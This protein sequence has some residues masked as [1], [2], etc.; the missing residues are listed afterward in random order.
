[1][2]FL[3]FLYMAKSYNKISIVISDRDE[4]E[5]KIKNSMPMPT[6]NYLR[7]FM[8][9]QE[10]LENGR[11]TPGCLTVQ[12]AIRPSALRRLFAYW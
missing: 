2:L 6:D 10:K 7:E 11:S 12:S 8:T 1:M 9:Q 4:T 5:K 3:H